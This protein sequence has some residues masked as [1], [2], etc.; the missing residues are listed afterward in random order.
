MSASDAHF[1]TK[2]WSMI[3]GLASTHSKRT[4]TQT[5]KT[6]SS[7]KAPRKWGQRVMGSTRLW[8]SSQVRTRKLRCRYSTIATSRSRTL[9]SISSIRRCRLMSKIGGKWMTCPLQPSA[10]LSRTSVPSV[11]PSAKEKRNRIK[12]ME[13]RQW[14]VLCKES[15]GWR[16]STRR[17][18]R[19]MMGKTLLTVHS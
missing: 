11:A 14:M 7:C 6:F 9:G 10:D 13:T 4:T 15:S 12:C 16:M 3:F 8:A 17:K 19:F 2:T 18:V 5:R 1:S